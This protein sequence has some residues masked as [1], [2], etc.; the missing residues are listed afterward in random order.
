M[1]VKLS[2]EK[3]ACSHLFIVEKHITLA[4]RIFPKMVLPG[5]QLPW[6]EMVVLSATIGEIVFLVVQ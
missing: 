4:P 5:A 6:A 3:L 1:Y 2:N